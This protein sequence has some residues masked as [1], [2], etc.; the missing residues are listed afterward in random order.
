[1]DALWCT[2]GSAVAN[3]VIRTPLHTDKEDR[4]GKERTKGKKKKKKPNG[5]WTGV[6]R[7]PLVA[8][9]GWLHYEKSK[10]TLDGITF[11]KKHLIIT[12]KH[13]QK[14]K[15]TPKAKV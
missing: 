5:D 9:H 15:K 12:E 4:E 2:R 8:W 13:V 6:N 1:M 11:F 3:R 14:Y 10:N 7:L